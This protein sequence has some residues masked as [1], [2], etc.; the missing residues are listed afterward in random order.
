MPCTTRAITELIWFK[1]PAPLHQSVPSDGMLHP[2]DVCNLLCAAAAGGR[3]V[4]PE[5]KQHM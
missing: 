2:V 3:K 4:D 5:L 1:S